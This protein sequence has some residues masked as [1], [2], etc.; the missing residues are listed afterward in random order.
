MFGGRMARGRP[1]GARTMT[2]TANELDLGADLHVLRATNI[3][4]RRHGH[5]PLLEPTTLFV[6]TG[7]VVVAVG[8]PGHGHTALALALAGRLRVDHGSV[9]L[10][11]AA[12]TK[13]LQRKVALVDVPG[14]SAPHNEV[15]L[16]T[17]VGEE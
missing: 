10:N 14:V 7:D 11:D 15:P 5:H 9:S 4:V 3:E 6:R 13:G 16:K 2:K 1:Q 17:I 12:G 8:E